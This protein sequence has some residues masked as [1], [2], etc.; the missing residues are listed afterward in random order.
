M[1]DNGD[2]SD[3]ARITIQPYHGALIASIQVDLEE[4]V[5]RQFQND[6]LECVRNN[7]ADVAIL[8]LSAVEIMDRED[9]AGLRRVIDMAALMGTQTVLCGMQPGVAA[10]LVELDVPLD[11]L[12]TRLS[13]EIALAEISAPESSTGQL[14]GSQDLDDRENVNGSK[15]DEALDRE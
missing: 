15:R 8:D 6:L 11:G 1:T 10:S 14:D 13:L 4:R 9:F 5:L 2:S 12:K 3:I 7:D